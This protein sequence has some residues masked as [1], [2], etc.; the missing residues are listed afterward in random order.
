[1][2]SVAG[3]SVLVVARTKGLHLI[4]QS[5]VVANDVLTSVESTNCSSY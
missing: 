4:K 5:Q 3:V 2:V 1:M